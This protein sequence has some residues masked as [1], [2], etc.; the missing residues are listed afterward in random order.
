[1]KQKLM[2]IRNLSKTDEARDKKV[3][4]NI[5]F[6]IFQGDIIALL[7]KSSSGKSTLLKMMSGLIAPSS[8]KITYLDEVITK[9]LPEISIV[10]QHFSLLPWLNVIDNIFLGMESKNYVMSELEKHQRAID[11][12]DKIGLSGLEYQYPKD[13]PVDMKQRVSIARSLVSDPMILLMDEPFCSLDILTA[14]SLKGDLWNIWKE[15]QNDKAMV[16]ITNNIEEAVLFSNKVVLLA[17]N[18][19]TANGYATGIKAVLSIDLPLGDRSYKDPKVIEIIDNIYDMM[20]SVTFFSKTKSFHMPDV[21]VSEVLGLLMEMHDLKSEG[22]IDLPL[23]AEHVQLDMEKLFPALE[24]LSLL[25]VADILK[26]DV[27]MKKSGYEILDAKDIEER[28]LVLKNLLIQHVPFA[29][30]I[31]TILEE[32]SSAITK[33]HLLELLNKNDEVYL[34]DLDIFIKWA[35]YTHLLD[36]T[37]SGEITLL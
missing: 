7:G 5:N 11:I 17:T 13:L 1:M 3:L 14:E 35:V 32:Y 12:L 33:H 28:K 31:I 15:E 26:G 36:Y 25:N 21:E 34:E 10:F 27:Q 29:Q 4:Q 20:S 24:M 6:D 9:P 8:G 19:L 23:L 2:S 30:K 18:N 37:S 16:F 22:M